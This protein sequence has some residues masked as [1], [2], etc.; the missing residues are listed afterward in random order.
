[1]TPNIIENHSE[2]DVNVLRIVQRIIKYLPVNILHGL[3]EIVI[4]D[5][6][7]ELDAFGCYKKSEK[8]IELYLDGITLWQP[9]LLKKTYVF[10]YLTIGM[11]LGHEIDHHVNRDNMN[12]NKETSAENNSL[13]YIYPSLGIF[14]PLF[15]IISI[16][17]K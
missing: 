10:P 17:R 9:W 7:N 12:I 8:R 11:A 13:N 4:L 3:K 5:E 15:R 2:K 16:L 14:K 1:M 6:N